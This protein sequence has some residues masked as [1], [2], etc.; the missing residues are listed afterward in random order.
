MGKVRGL[1]CTL[2]PVLRTWLQPAQLTIC[3]SAR[4]VKKHTGRFDW[5][6][7]LLLLSPAAPCLQVDRVL[8]V[9]TVSAREVTKA[10]FSSFTQTQAG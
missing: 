7:L 10:L 8:A 2:V 9:R 4:Q 5:L 1:A 3:C 6:T